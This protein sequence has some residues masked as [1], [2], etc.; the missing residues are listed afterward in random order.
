ML[1][2]LSWFELTAEEGNALLKYADETQ[3]TFEIG[4]LLGFAY[5]SRDKR[6]KTKIRTWLNRYEPEQ[7]QYWQKQLIKN[8]KIVMEMIDQSPACNSFLHEKT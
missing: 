6:W 8:L 3:N 1:N 7:E 4:S 5:E 2:R